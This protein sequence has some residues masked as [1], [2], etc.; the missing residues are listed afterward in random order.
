MV[1]VEEHRGR[2]GG[3]PMSVT[4]RMQ[5]APLGNTPS[6]GERYPSSG[7]H[8]D[9]EPDLREQ[10]G[11][12][13]FQA[14]R[15]LVQLVAGEVDVVKQA[16]HKKLATMRDELA[17]PQPT[18]LE[19]L[20]VERVVACWPQLHY[21]D[22][23]LAQRAKEKCDVSTGRLLRAAAGPGPPALPAGDPHAC[24]VRRLLTSAMQVNIGAGQLNVAQVSRTP[25]RRTPSSRARR[26]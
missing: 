1:V 13:A 20:L 7:K 4:R 17:G 8:F 9:R 23:I 6:R 16:V 18:A 15:S 2:V 26:R 22:A 24:E 12:L 25:R 21:A 3:S 11:D 14:E 19:G 5:S 10:R